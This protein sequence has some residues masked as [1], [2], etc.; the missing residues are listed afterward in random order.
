MGVTPRRQR[1][2]GNDGYKDYPYSMHPSSQGLP[3]PPD[4]R[5]FSESNVKEEGEDYGLD[6]D[7]FENDDDCSSNEFVYNIQTSPDWIGASRKEKNSRA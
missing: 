4:S 2:C 6:F 7:H 1:H 3:P 5:L